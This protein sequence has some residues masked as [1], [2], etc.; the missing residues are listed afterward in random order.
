MVDQITTGKNTTPKKY[1][2]LSR[3]QT[4][5]Q[6]DKIYNKIKTKFDDNS[7]ETLDLT[8]RLNDVLNDNKY[9]DLDTLWE[10]IEK[11]LYDKKSLGVPAKTNS[12][13]LQTAFALFY[14]ALNDLDKNASSTLEINSFRSIFTKAKQHL[15][16]HFLGRET[17][18]DKRM[19]ERVIK[20]TESR[21]TEVVERYNEMASKGKIAGPEI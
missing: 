2:D 20:T 14:N 1:L 13:K 21:L 18:S 7:I 11:E 8:R 4:M 9:A 12:K 5:V 16:T 6:A 15:E 17:G 10:D 3:P 19:L